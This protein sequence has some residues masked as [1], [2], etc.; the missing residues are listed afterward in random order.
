MKKIIIAV[1]LIQIINLSA[2]AQMQVGQGINPW[3][4]KI[5]Q[6]HNMAL[7]PMSSVPTLHLLVV[8]DSMHSIVIQ[9]KSLV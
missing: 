4:N 8:L 9:L 3:F 5:P 6:I 1:V 2:V 7:M